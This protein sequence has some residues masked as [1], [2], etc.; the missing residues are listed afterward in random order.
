MCR[1]GT[2]ASNTFVSLWNG[3]EENVEKDAKDEI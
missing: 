3:C 2:S 1:L